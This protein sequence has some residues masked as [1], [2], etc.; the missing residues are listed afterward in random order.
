MDIAALD[1]AA[2]ASFNPL[3]APFVP[4]VT[5]TQDGSTSTRLLKRGE[6]VVLSELR[7][8]FRFGVSGVG[9]LCR[10]N[11]YGY[12]V[13]VKE[14]VEKPQWAQHLVRSSGR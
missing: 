4:S 13:W 8:E 9:V 10:L 12:V 3:P 7:E 1:S 14:E 11:V 5:L 6:L 2:L